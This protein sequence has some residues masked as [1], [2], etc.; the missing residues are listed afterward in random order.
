[1]RYRGYLLIGEEGRTVAFP[2][3]T[4][5]VCGPRQLVQ[6]LIDR[7]GQKPELPAHL[8]A[9]LAHIGH[10]NQMWVVADGQGVELCVRPVA[11][12]PAAARLSDRIARVSL[13]V[14][15]GEGA[16]VWTHVE[17]VTPGDAMSLASQ[18][19]VAWQTWQEGPQKR[20]PSTLLQ[21]AAAIGWRRQGNSLEATLELAPTALDQLWEELRPEALA[22]PPVHSILGSKQ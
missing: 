16:K 12:L 18:W 22:M 6:R 17:C 4:T 2:N 13:A 11:G 10:S 9:P 21:L 15:F 3:T 19:A 5:A 1:M 8:L 7:R 20:P 14:T